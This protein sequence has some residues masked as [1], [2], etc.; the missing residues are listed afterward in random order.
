M[1]YN[2]GLTLLMDGDGNLGSVPGSFDADYLTFNGGGIWANG[3]FT[4]NAN[5][6]MT[7]TGNGFIGSRNNRTLTYGGVI[8]GSG[9]LTKNYDGTLLLSGT[10]TYT[11]STIILSLIH[12]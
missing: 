11:G 10:N 4:I 1:T 7:L 12:I 8:T 3:S 5:R 2:A 6:G 9:N